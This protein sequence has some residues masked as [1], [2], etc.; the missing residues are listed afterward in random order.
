[1]NNSPVNFVDPT[2]HVCQDYDLSGHIV[3]VCLNDGRWADIED[4]TPVGNWYSNP[5]PHPIKKPTVFSRAIH[6]DG[7]AI[8]DLVVPTHFGGRV[9]YEKS[10]DP[11]I[12]VSGTVGVNLVYNRVSDE[13]AY[14][15]DVSGTGGAGT[16]IGDA[17]TGGILVGWESSDVDDAT[18]GSTPVISATGA[19]IAAVT[20]SVS[21]TLQ[22]D[23]IYG[24]APFTFYLGAGPG[25]AFADI[26]GG[27]NKTI[28]H[29]D[30]TKFLPWHWSMWK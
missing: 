20:A 30:L 15:I 10:F 3:G 27:P 13:L 22:E 5:E 1:V 23:P 16:G 29:G 11:G 19:F 18:T 9:Q 12:S 14:S 21:S 2:G 26:G 25:G 7:A 4:G 28:V 24:Q 6:G 17:V 8:I